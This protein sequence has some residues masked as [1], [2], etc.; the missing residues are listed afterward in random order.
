MLL[1]QHIVVVGDPADEVC[2]Y[3][4]GQ[5][6]RKIAEAVGCSDRTVESIR[7][8]VFGKILGAPSGGGGNASKMIKELAGEVATL[9]DKLTDLSDKYNR[10]CDTLSINKIFDVRHLKQRTEAGE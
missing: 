4:N 1:Q 8:S 3:R 6:D 7:K 5:S 2:K 9:E 10:L